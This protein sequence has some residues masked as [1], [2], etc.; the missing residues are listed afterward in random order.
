[1]KTTIE[2]ANVAVI[3]ADDDFSS[4]AGATT[5]VFDNIVFWNFGFS[6]IF[7]FEELKFS[8]LV[9]LFLLLLYVSSASLHTAQR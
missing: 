2:E 1:M 4:T 5:N 6:T 8:L 7:F 3:G 9:H